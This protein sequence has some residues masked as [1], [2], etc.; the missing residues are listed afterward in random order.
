M[1]Y[2]DTIIYNF[3]KYIAREKSNLFKVRSCLDV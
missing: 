2:N 1:R 3:E